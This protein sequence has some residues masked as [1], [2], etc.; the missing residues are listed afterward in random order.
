MVWLVVESLVF[1][2]RFR[3]HSKAEWDSVDR[4]DRVWFQVVK[5]CESLDEA[6]AVLDQLSKQAASARKD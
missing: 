4:A 6:N 2:N 1:P 5:E 3:L